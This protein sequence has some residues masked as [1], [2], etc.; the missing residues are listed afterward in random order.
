MFAPFTQAL[1]EEERLL[2][3]LIRASISVED[4]WTLR[5]EMSEKLRTKLASLSKPQNAEL[6]RD[7]LEA[8]SSYSSERGISFPAEVLIVSGG[9]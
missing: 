8:L 4:F 3:F 7:V 6:K 1:I 5:S 2:R 9:K